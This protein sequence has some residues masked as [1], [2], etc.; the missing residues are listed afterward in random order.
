M[1]FDEASGIKNVDYWRFMLIYRFL[2]VGNSVEDYF[3]KIISNDT[4]SN[5]TISVDTISVDTISIDTISIDTISIDSI[6][7]YGLNK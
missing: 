6:F 3:D 7:I 2:R 1:R 5:D 4:I